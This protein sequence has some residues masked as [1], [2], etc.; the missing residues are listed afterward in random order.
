MPTVLGCLP[1]TRD[2]YS[3]LTTGPTIPKKQM[4][5]GRLIAYSVDTVLPQD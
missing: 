1:K 3:R 5:E 4:S 2:G